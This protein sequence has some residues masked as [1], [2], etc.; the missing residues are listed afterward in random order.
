MSYPRHR[1]A[2]V[3]PRKP[4]VQIEYPSRGETYCRDEYGVYEYSEY[5]QSSV[6]AGQER[7]R[8]LDSFPT[9]EEART[10]AKGLGVKVEVAIG[11]GYRT[12][13]LNHLPDGAD[14]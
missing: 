5:P 12:P 7:R 9:L 8:F 11:T 1:R 13:S 4:Q 2:P 10:F 3:R 14:L 6:L